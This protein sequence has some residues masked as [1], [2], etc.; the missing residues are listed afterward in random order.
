MR[1]TQVER[2]IYNL[3][4][5]RFDLDARYDAPTSKD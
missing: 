4:E 3:T 2:S 1:G 5:L